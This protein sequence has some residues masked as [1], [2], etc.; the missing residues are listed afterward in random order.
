MLNFN[1]G[2]NSVQLFDDGECGGFTIYWAYESE[3]NPIPE[4]YRGW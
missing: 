4:E 1:K 2:I 3:S